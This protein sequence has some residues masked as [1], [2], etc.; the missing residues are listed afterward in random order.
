MI[1]SWRLCDCPPAV[2]AHGELAGAGHL[3]VYCRGDEDRCQSIWYQP[4]HEPARGLTA[5]GCDS[6]LGS[7][8]PL[9]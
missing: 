2:A 1:V 3:V 8:V 7:P 5:A 6:S 4:R 9:R